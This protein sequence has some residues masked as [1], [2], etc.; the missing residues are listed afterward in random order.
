MG[1][2]TFGATG[3]AV[4][5]S[6][7]AP[8]APK[9]SSSNSGS[10]ALVKGD[11]D[12]DGILDLVDFGSGGTNYALLK[13]NANG[14]FAAPSGLSL[15]ATTNS[16]VSAVV[17][18]VNNDGYPDIVYYNTLGVDVLI[19]NKAGGFHPVVTV[20]TPMVAAKQVIVGDFNGDGFLDIAFGGG[21]TG[22]PDTGYFQVIYGDGSGTNYTAGTA[23]PSYNVG[24]P[25]APVFAVGAYDI[26]GDGYADLFVNTYQASAT[27]SYYAGGP[28]GISGTAGPNGTVPAR[29]FTTASTGSASN[30]VFA[31]LAN[32]G[33]T[34]VL[35]AYGGKYD[36]AVSSCGTLPCSFAVTTTAVTG[37][38]TASGATVG[39]FNN[40]GVLDVAFGTSLGT[41]VVASGAGGS[42]YGSDWCA[43]NGCFR[44]LRPT[45]RP[46]RYTRWLQVTSPVTA[47][48]TLLLRTWSTR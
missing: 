36:L 37:L 14:S 44:I 31:D 26:D 12:R 27:N 16:V 34:D 24:N 13:G 7:P 47:T 39:D 40:D 43:G 10:K 2:V 4:T 20:Y 21:A 11:F 17:A 46:R 9:F 48:R 42:G 3:S 19:N 45:F 38:V 28:G 30:F 25:Y 23:Y 15:V 41:A 18:D 29:A 5:F 1:T 22:T 6:P 8:Y 35:Y 33:V 32:D